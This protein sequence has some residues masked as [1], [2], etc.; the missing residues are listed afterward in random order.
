MCNSH[1]SHVRLKRK[2][3][4]RIGLEKESVLLN[5]FSINFSCEVAMISCL[6]LHQ[7]HRGH[8]S[9][10]HRLACC[11]FK[12]YCD[13]LT[14]AHLNITWTGEASNTKAF[15]LFVDCSNIHIFLCICVQCS[16]PFLI[17]MCHRQ[18]LLHV[19]FFFYFFFLNMLCFCFGL[20]KLLLLIPSSFLFLSGGWKEVLFSSG[21]YFHSCGKGGKCHKILKGQFWP[22]I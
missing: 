16:H 1:L 14:S 2:K 6:F 22:Q 5:L 12:L 15:H 8:L 10:C 4:K 20:A 11:F 3:H 18:F 7:H 9:A 19:F 21:A 17:L 13:A